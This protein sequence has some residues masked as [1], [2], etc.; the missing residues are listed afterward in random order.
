[1]TSPARSMRTV[2][3]TRTSFFRISSSLWKLTLLTVTPASSTG[4]SWAVGV[5]APVLPTLIV[6][7]R[8]RV[9]A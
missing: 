7:P 4:S 9:V 1:M 8:T 6:M 5:S 3:P 2:S